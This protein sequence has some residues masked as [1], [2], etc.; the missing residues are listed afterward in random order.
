MGGCESKSAIV[1]V[2]RMESSA[3]FILSG[4]CKGWGIDVRRRHKYSLVVAYICDNSDADKKRKHEIDTNANN[5]YANRDREKSPLPSDRNRF[6]APALVCRVFTCTV[7]RRWLFRVP[8]N[9]NR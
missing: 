6:T 7:G 2:R 1:R 8:E 4:I 3:Q 5:Y 9:F